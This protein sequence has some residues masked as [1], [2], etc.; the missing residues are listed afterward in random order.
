MFTIKITA[1]RRTCY[2]ELSAAYENPLESPCDI[3]VGQI[4][5]SENA[6]RPEDLCDSA[7]QTMQP[8]VRDLAQGGGNF[9]DGW[10]KDPRTA[11]VSCNDGFRPVSFF[12]QVCEEEK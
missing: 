11:M 5:Y 1:M 2:P 8:F 3:Q 6:E 7:W 4:F 10:M 12:M 9:F